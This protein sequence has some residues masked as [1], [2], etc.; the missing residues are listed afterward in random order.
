MAVKLGPEDLRKLCDP[1]QF[2]FATTDDVVAQ[3]GT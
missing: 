3:G 2:N 1:D